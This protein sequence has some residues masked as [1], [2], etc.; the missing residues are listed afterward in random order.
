[1]SNTS[2]PKPWETGT[3]SNPSQPSISNNTSTATTAGNPTA[4]EIPA[5]PRTMGYN[6]YGAGATG[7][8]YGGYGSVGGY[9]AGYGGYGGGNYGGGYGAGT[10]GGGYGGGMYNRYGTGMYGNNMYGSG[11]YNRRPMEDSLTQQMEQSTATTFQTLDSIVQAFMGFSHMLESTFVATQSSF[12]AMVG[13]AEQFG[14]L[15]SYLGQVFSIVSLYQSLKNLGYR[16]T[17]RSSPQSNPLPTTGPK[18]SKKPLFFFLALIVG[19]PFLM[20]KLIKKLE[21]QKQIDIKNIEFCK[22]LYDFHSDQPGD[23]PFR[24]GDLV[25]VLGKEGGDWWRGRTQDGRMGLFPSTYVKLI[26]KIESPTNNP[27]GPNP[28]P[29]F[30]VQEFQ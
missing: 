3:V 26:P 12:M 8:A 10:Y 16:L 24:N 2:P 30:S 7:N 29:E 13:V 27:D 18:P 4:P 5:R 15:K 19:L 9:G 1:M 14:Q 22:A 28:V 6:N 23:L 21:S 11:M 20:S 17:G 25:A